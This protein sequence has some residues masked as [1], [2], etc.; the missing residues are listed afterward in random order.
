[1]ERTALQ[2]HKD[3]E[4]QRDPMGDHGNSIFTVTGAWSDS[5]IVAIPPCASS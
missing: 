4:Q 3:H 5:G 1:V 2:G